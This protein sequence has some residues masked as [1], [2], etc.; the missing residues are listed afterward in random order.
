MPHRHCRDVPVLAVAPAGPE[1]LANGLWRL[2][3]EN[4]GF[5]GV[6]PGQFAMLRPPA[7]GFDPLWARPLSISRALDDRIVFHFLVAG[8]GTAAFTRLAP[9][10]PVTVWGPLG[11]GFAVEPGAPTLLV[12]GGI[13]IAPFVEYAATHPTPG[14]LALLFGHRPPRSCYP[15]DELGAMIAVESFQDKTPEDIPR[16][17]ELLEK[18]IAEHAGGLVLACGPTPL[19]RSVKNLADKHGVRAQVSLENRMAC[20]V[21]ACLG[22]VAENPEGHRVQTC[23][24]GPVFWADKVTL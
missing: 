3:L 11:Q 15:Y 10:E 18:R 4:P 7:W 16:F 23:V 13:G 1:G 22:C 8:R 21:G 2:E 9:G 17:V 19:L 6:K 5:T 20:G 14:K 24:K 12:G